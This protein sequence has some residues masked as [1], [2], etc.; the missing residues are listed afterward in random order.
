MKIKNT[1]DNK[2][3][4]GGGTKGEAMNQTNFPYEEERDVKQ[5]SRNDE[6]IFKNE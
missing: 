2:R 4:G 1:R 5:K 3:A 6:L